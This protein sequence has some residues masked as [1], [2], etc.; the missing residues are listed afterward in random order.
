MPSLLS[1]KYGPSTKDQIEYSFKRAINSDC[2]LLILGNSRVYRGLN[3]AIWH[4]KAVKFAHDKD[5]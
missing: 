3:P 1:V 2:N 4:Q 5:S